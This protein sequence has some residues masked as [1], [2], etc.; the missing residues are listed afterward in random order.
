LPGLVGVPASGLPVTISALS[1]VDLGSRR[2]EVTN[3]QYRFLGGLKGDL[4]DWHWE[5]AALY[6]WATA[7][8]T[9]VNFSST[10]LQAA[11][12]RTTPDAYNPFNGGCP[13]T[14]AGG[15]CTP[16]NQATIDS[17]RIEATRRNKTTL[18]LADFK[19][20]TPSLLN[21]WS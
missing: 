7:A 16:N 10:K 15:D 14:P 4:G 3:Y 2:V 17:S 12:N 21:L 6:T 11:I 9:Q 20:S 18:A 5:T 13:T 19:I 1:Y 8:D